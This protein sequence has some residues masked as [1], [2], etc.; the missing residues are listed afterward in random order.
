VNA[1]KAAGAK[2][3]DVVK[4]SGT[5]ADKVKDKSVETTKKGIDQV[6]DT[7]GDVKEQTAKGVDVASKSAKK[8]G[9]WFTNAFK[10]IF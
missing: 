7:A 10:K 9:N 2:T 4:E 6:G 8:T 3:K 1:T 5:T